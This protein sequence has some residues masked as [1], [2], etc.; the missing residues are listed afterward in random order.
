MF[1]IDQEIIVDFKETVGSTYLKTV[2][3][4]HFF[5]EIGGVLQIGGIGGESDAARGAK[6][7]GYIQHFPGGRQTTRI[8]RPGSAL[9][10]G[11]D[12]AIAG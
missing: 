4:D 6:V 9:Q 11:L 8:T 5:L 3:A 7:G 1:D 2:H 10:E 12:P